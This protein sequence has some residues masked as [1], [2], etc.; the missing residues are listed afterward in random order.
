MTIEEMK[1]KKKDKGYTYAMMA[2]MSGVPLGTIQKIFSG[3]TTAPRYDTLV[4]L[5]RIFEDENKAPRYTYNLKDD[6]HTGM[7]MDSGVAYSVK[8]QG[9]YTVDDY[10]A[11]PEERRVE[12]IDGCIYDMAAPTTFHQLIAGE[13]YRQI[14]NYILG[15]GGKCTPFISPVDVQLDCDEKTMIQPDVVILCDEDKLKAFGIYGA[16]D[17]VLEVTSKSTK[18]RDYGKKLAKYMDA[19]VRE[20]WIV[21]PYQKTIL[22]YDFTGDVYPVI[23]GMDADVPVAIYHGELTINISGLIGII[24]KLLA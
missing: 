4:A 17:F 8:K 23:Y 15:K 11:I 1:T 16:P 13:V 21:N 20:Y 14:S 6:S 12:L 7:I 22:V 9:E 24:D 18:T 2:E 19:G 3:E 10:R 5:E